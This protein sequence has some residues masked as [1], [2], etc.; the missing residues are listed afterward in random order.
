MLLGH[1]QCYCDKS[2]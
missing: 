2:D 1:L